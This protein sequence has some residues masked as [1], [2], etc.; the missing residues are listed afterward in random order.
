VNCPACSNPLIILEL[1]EI[2]I[3]YCTDCEGIWLDSGELELLLEDSDEKDE[4]LASFKP[5]S[6]QKEKHIKCPICR[7]KMNKV[8]VDSVRKI[9]LDKCENECGIWFDKGE[10]LDVIKLGSEN[11]ENKVIKLLYDMFEYKIKQ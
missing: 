11:E 8:L 4:L 1:N 9:T 10:L 5:D 6:E 2:E 3:D 7:K